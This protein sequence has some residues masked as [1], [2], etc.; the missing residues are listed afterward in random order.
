MKKIILTCITSILPLFWVSTASAVS[1]TYLIDQ[2]NDLADDINYATV[3]IS[4][5]GDDI[6]FLVKIIESSFD[7][8]GTSNFGIQSFDFN[9]DNGIT[10]GVDNIDTLMPITWSIDTG[11]N[12][13]GGFGKFGFNLDGSGSSRTNEISFSI[14]GVDGD[15][16]DSYASLN[17]LNPA[18]SEFFAMHIAGFNT[19]NE[20]TSAKFAGSTA[21]GPFCAAG[22]DPD[23]NPVPLPAAAWLFGSSLVGLVGFSRRK[24]PLAYQA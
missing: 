17:N 10:V 22:Q 12:A 16:I 24:S 21:C 11:K 23:L 2:S 9:Y 6:D 4:E 15:T 14:T 13:G 1:M 5:N 7:T 18:S 19:T 8:S 3:T 20:K